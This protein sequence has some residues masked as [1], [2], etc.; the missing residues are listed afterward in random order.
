MIIDCKTQGEWKIQ[1][2]M[3]INLISSNDSDETCNLRTKS[4]NIEI[5]SVIRTD[6]IVDEFFE[7]F[8]Q[9]YQKH[10]DKSVRQ[11]EFIFDSVDLLY[12]NLQKTSLNKKG[13]SYMAS[14]EWLKNKKAK[15]NPKNND[16]NCFQYVL[17][18]TL[19]YQNI[20]NHPECV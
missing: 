17:I 14:P 16:N 9:N 13:S 1:L 6:E 8:S 15:I 20:K 5:W 19:N 7:S 18:A 3:S 2:T 11:S 10:L 12:Y 4:D